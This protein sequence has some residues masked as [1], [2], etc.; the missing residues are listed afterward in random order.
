MS[1]GHFRSPAWHA[2][3]V[4]VVSLVFL[5]GSFAVSSD[6]QSQISTGG[7]ESVDGEAGKDSSQRSQTLYDKAMA[8]RHVQPVAG[9]TDG[10]ALVL[11]EN[12]DDLRRSIHQLYAA[13]G[14]LHLSM[15]ASANPTARYHT[16]D[17]VEIRWRNGKIQHIDA[18]RELIYAFRSGTGAPVNPAIAH[19]LVRELAAAGVA[20]FQCDLGAMYSLGV[21]PVAQNSDDVMFILTRPDHDRSIMHY[22]FSAKAGDPVARMALGYRHMYGIGVRKSC[23]LSVVYYES[24]AEGVVS[25]A[26]ELGG[27]P[28]TSDK[29]FAD[30][31][32]ALGLKPMPTAEQEMFHYQWFADYG[33]AEAARAVAHLLTHGEEQNLG[34][35]LEY[36]LQAAD[37]GDADAMAH[38]GHAYA[39]G[40][41]VAQNNATAKS[42]F[43]KAAG[44]GH[45]SGLF[46]LGLLHLNGQGVNVDHT[47]AAQYFNRA[48]TIDRDWEGKADAYFY[49]GTYE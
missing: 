34:A 45:P 36:L 21:E 17:D 16:A 12:K 4:I 29:R 13:A 19:K 38:I 40:I 9:S 7:T 41:A 10:T 8:L 2:I 11:N 18:V 44:K 22:M 26:R 32:A 46:G 5:L 14:V 15:N 28:V 42:W 33:H 39:N 24:V 47:M 31:R 23:P 25:S 6:V 30:R 37:L 35:A 43:V 20:E 1:R 49:A 27:L 48:V 3:A